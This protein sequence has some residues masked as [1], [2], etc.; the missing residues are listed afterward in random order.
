MASRAI[1]PKRDDTMLSNWQ[2]TPETAPSVVQDD[3]PGTARVLALIG[4]ILVA[5]GG[6][7]VLAPT[8]KKVYIIGPAT[9]VFCLA[10][11]LIL[12]VFHALTDRDVQYRLMYLLIGYLGIGVGVAL[13]L[14]PFGGSVGALFLSI[15]LPALVL[16]LIFVLAAIRHETDAKVRLSLT[17]PLAALGFTLI[18]MGSFAGNLSQQFL[19]PEGILISLIGLIFIGAFLGT[20]GPGTDIGYGVGAG[21]GLVGIV[22][23]AVV[24]FRSWFGTMPF[25]VPS[26]VVLLS[27]SLIHLLV[28]L[29]VC[30]D[31][32]VL[33]LF[34]RE[35]RAFFVSPIGHLVFLENVLIAWL[36]FVFFQNGVAISAE[37]GGMLE[38]IVRSYLFNYFVVISQVFIVPVLTMRLFSEEKKS[39]TLE[40]LL[41]A[42]VSESSVVIGKFAAAFVAYLFTW[43]PWFGFLIAL[44]I[45]TGTDFEYRP[46]LSFLAAM[47]LTGMG[48][49]AIGLFFSSITSNQIIAAVLTFVAMIMQSL[50]FFRDFF[51]IREG[52]IWNDIL[53]YVSPMDLWLNS[54]YGIL[55]PRFFLYHLSVAVFFLFLSTRALEARRWT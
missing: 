32:P 1:K 20:Q 8:F 4:L 52:S 12:L 26:G 48:F 47:M 53:T 39:G 7:A 35:L 28:G 21:V 33:V 18:V 23:L 27:I 31:W 9:G 5:F 15:G 14:L 16:G 25:I 11:G 3:A 44:R 37:R 22:G 34:R 30:T 50:P 24:V 19:M 41:T 42:P 49:I 17:I 43:A 45:Y 51:E 40:V 2:S 36:W 13:R 29:C 6:F 10:L 54:L 55:A 38:P 46:L